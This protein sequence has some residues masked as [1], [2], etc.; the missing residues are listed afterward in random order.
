MKT[1]GLF[2]TGYRSL[3]RP[4]KLQ[5]HLLGI[6]S[7]ASSIANPKVD[8]L[9]LETEWHAKWMTS[10]DKTQ[11]SDYRKNAYHPLAPL[12]YKHLRT[13]TA[14]SNL[15][16]YNNVEGGAAAL[17]KGKSS[18]FDRILELVRPGGIERLLDHLDSSMD[19]KTCIGKYGSDITR[20]YLIED[21][22]PCNEKEIIQIQQWFEVIWEAILLAHAS[23]KGTQ[24]SASPLSDI[25]ATLY[26]PNLENW[27]D[28]LT[29]TPRSW[30]HILPQKPEV[31]DLEMQAE[32]IAV[33]L[34][35][36][37]ALL[38]MTQPI[39]ARNS[40]QTIESRL[41]RLAKAIKKYD[42]AEIVLPDVHYHSA[43]ILLCLI[44]P[45]APSFAEEC[46][47]VLHYGNSGSEGWDGTS[48][49]DQEMIEKELAEDEAL[50]HLPRR[51]RPETLGSIFD[52]PFPVAEPKKTMDLLKNPSSLSEARAARRAEV[53]KADKPRQERRR[54][55]RDKWNSGSN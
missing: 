39:G 31:L 48:E 26:E 16:R 30:V 44:A 38:S 41:V 34:S 4:H 35:A 28:Y 49:S 8:F 12:Y 23:Y 27:V 55:A 14:M 5:H 15:V 22:P 32:H 19:M 1:L 50:R 52:E 3:C 6:L 29:D 51:G 43:R 40:L 10:E 20:T 46:W 42:D 37:K 33:W 53:E 36:Q 2:L 21:N 17:K 45:F 54:L 25:P 9:A 11:P 47:V 24:V 18:I 7:R 13:L